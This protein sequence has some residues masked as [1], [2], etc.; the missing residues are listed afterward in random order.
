MSVAKFYAYFSSLA[1]N[2]RR[3]PLYFN[4]FRIQIF[5]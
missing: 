5:P 2:R 1:F 4:F 3:L